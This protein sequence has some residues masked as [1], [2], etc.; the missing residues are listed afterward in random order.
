MKGGD[1][2]QLVII[3]SQDTP[4]VVEGEG[5]DGGDDQQLVMF[6]GQD[7]R[8]GI[9]PVVISIHDTPV[10][11]MGRKVW[12]IERVVKLGL[13]RKKASKYTSSPFRGIGRKKT[14]NK[15]TVTEPQN[16]RLLGP[17][18][19]LPKSHRVI[20]INNEYMCAEDLVIL[21]DPVAWLTSPLMNVYGEYLNVR[22]EQNRKPGERACVSISTY[23]YDCITDK[24]YAGPDSVEKYVC[25][26]NQCPPD[27]LKRVLFPV[28]VPQHWILLVLD[29]VDE[30]FYIYN[31][32]KDVKYWTE[33]RPLVRYLEGLYLEKWKV[34]V[35]KFL[36]EELDKRPIQRNSNDCGLFV[37]KEMD[38]LARDVPPKFSQAEITVMRRQLLEDFLDGRCGTTVNL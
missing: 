4:E 28:H 18:L 29:M 30:K 12:S 5:P 31:S 1:D 21:N 14:N 25:R 27:T 8:K 15:Q 17:L 6:G 10:K 23:L 16:H 11:P 2:R 24:G 33:V 19:A 3:P 22:D 36:V 9:E 37:L 32:L 26:L 13:R 34:D 35:S 20:Q 38:C 7:R